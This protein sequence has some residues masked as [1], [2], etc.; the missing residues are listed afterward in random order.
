M[1]TFDSIQEAA[2]KL[3][4]TFKLYA[5]L[6][7]RELPTIIADQSRRL[8]EQVYFNT[9][10]ATREQIAA[11]VMRNAPRFKRAPK[12]ARSKGK[13]TL[14]V[15]IQDA[16]KYRQAQVG[17]LRASFVLVLRQLG[18]TLRVAASQQFVN[19]DAARLE[20]SFNAMEVVTR[21]PGFAKINDR[22]A[23][24]ERAFRDREADLQVYIARKNSEIAIKALET[25]KK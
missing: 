10:R 2:T 8:I 1:K 20:Q 5:V 18:S 17:A 19:S 24:V 3:E 11:D 12:R 13:K 9:T 25:I 6:N 21:F 14:K 7:E 23:I 15:Q 4:E 22:D 16:I